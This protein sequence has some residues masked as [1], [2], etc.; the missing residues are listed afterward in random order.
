[1][2]S[3]SL[4]PSRLLPKTVRSGGLARSAAELVSHLLRDYG[5][6]RSMKEGRCVD[7][8]GRSIPWFTYP[9][10]DFLAQFDYAKRSV[11]EYGSG[12][13]TFFWA[14]RAYRVIAVENDPAWYEVVRAKVPPNCQLILS[15][16]DV[17]VY[18]GQIRG[19]E[20]FDV[21]SIDGTGESRPMCCRRALEHLRPGGMIIL[22][23]SD[24]WLKSAS[25]LRTAGLIQV[26]F[27]GFGPLESHAH[28]TSVFLTR[29]FNFEALRG[30]Q[31]HKSVAQPAEPWPDEG[32]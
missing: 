24:L 22:D 18:S 8:N 2:M 23:N 21:V 11:F 4:F 25:I 20:S 7:R 3:T 10:I 6:L 26:D 13:S 5:W 29:D 15:V 12:A 16:S 1:M 27:T 19:R 30:Y 9:A 28:T 14:E 31:P 32:P 17:D